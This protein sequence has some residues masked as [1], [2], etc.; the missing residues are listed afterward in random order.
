MT[1][2]QDIEG[3]DATDRALPPY[4]GRR[5]GADVEG[6]GAVHRGGANVGGATGPAESSDMK[7]PAKE[8]TPRGAE[9]SPSDEQPASET[10]DSNPN[11]DQGVGPA[12]QPGTGRGEDKSQDER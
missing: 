7:S 8:D 1:E 4:E 12:H 9:A 11:P 3:G 2:S 5:E 10:S 6:E